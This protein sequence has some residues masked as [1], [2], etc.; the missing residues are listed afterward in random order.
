[1][2]F[3][4]K[5]TPGY[6]TMAAGQQIIYVISDDTSVM[7][8]E[9]M[10]KVNAQVQVNRLQSMNPAGTI[11][12]SSYSSTPNSAGVCIFDFGKIIENYVTP[13]YNGVISD[14]PSTASSFQGVDYSEDT[15]Y[16]S[17]HNI[18]KY[19][20]APFEHLRKDL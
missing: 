3:V 7:T 14:I 17:I 9:L 6:L 11:H 16:H 20:L 1:M 5:Q 13:Q 19:C 10:V 4:V 12:S 2:A 18:D 15:A 8:T